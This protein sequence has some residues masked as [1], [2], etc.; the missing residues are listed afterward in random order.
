MAEGLARKLFGTKIHVQSAGSKPSKVNPYAIRVMEEIGI[1]ISHHRSKSVNEIDLS[2][3]DLVITLC[4]EEIC[5]LVPAKT[6]R[7]H[8]PTPN[9]AGRGG[10]EDEQLNRFRQTRDALRDRIKTL[11]RF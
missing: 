9:P 7:L 3:I 2:K 4:A 11:A 8:W 6:K 5:P 10:S 1:D